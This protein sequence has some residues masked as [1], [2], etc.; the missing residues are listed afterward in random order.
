MN[1]YFKDEIPVARYPELDDVN[2][3]G[4]FCHR[5][6]VV[7]KR[8]EKRIPMERSSPSFF[9][10]QREARKREEDGNAC[11]GG[12]CASL[13]APKVEAVDE[14][15]YKIPPELIFRYQTMKRKRVLR[16]FSRCLAP[17]C[18]M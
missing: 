7:C 11:G 10:I 9:Y 1:W 5:N 2:H 8:R 15:L 4:R 16:F 6:H 17:A 13:K 18:T 3:A 12:P 14:D